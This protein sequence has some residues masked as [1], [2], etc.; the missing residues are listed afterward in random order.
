MKYHNP[1]PQC[2]HCPPKILTP[3]KLYLNSLPPQ[4][5]KSLRP[6]RQESRKLVHQYILN[7]IRLLD[8]D[9]DADA[10][11]TWLDQNSFVFVAGDG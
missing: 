1:M 3:Q 11:H 9:T 2:Q 7:L 4:Y 6:L 10:V 5:E 8:L